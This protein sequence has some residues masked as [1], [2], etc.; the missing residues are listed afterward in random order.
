MGK[1]HCE[2][3]GD[4]VLRKE[5]EG[6]IMLIEKEI[7]SNIL[8]KIREVIWIVGDCECKTRMSGRPQE[9]TRRIIFR[10]N[11]DRFFLTSA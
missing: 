11:F 3:K 4:H 10:I 5:E 2:K 1:T 8:G 6:I 9:Y 7:M